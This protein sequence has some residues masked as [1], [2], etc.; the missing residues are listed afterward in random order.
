MTYKEKVDLFFQ[1]NIFAVVGVSRSGSKVGN[2]IYKKLKDSGYQAF[3]VNPN[4]DKVE[5]DACYPTIGSI[6][7]KA[8]SVLVAT[9]PKFAL[10][11]VKEAIEGKV[12]IIWFHKGM[13]EGSYN[14][15]AA[16]Y[17]ESNGIIA[18]HSGCPMM[19]I[20]NADGFHRFI[21]VIFRFFG[22]LKK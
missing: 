17:A 5:G 9:H 14:K 12:K 6:P 13:G 4:T 1:Q 18:I 8:E 20:K 16:E 15:E 2:A 22:K 3:P 7:F 21:A 19:F 10:N 11:I